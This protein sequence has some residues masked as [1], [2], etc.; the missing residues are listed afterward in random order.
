MYRSVINHVSK[1]II[2]K[3][4]PHPKI[5]KYEQRGAFRSAAE[6][7]RRGVDEHHQTIERK[8]NTDFRP[9]T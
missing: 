9:T 4:R 5:W 8:D 3:R 6:L 7:I 2:E 1:K